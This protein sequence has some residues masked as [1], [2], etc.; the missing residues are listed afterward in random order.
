MGRIVLYSRVTDDN[1]GR[2]SGGRHLGTRR[3]DKGA[4]YVWSLGP[5]LPDRFRKQRNCS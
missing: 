2:F 3:A 1:G 4:S 5:P